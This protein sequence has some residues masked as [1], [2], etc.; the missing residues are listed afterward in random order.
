MEDMNQDSDI[1][2]GYLVKQ[3]QGV[4]GRRV[5]ELINHTISQSSE[6]KAILNSRKAKPHPFTIYAFHI[7]KFLAEYVLPIV[8]A[9][10]ISYTYYTASETKEP[11]PKT[12]KYRPTTPLNSAM[13][14]GG[15]LGEFAHGLLSVPVGIILGFMDKGLRLSEIGD[16]MVKSRNAIVYTPAAGFVGNEQFTYTISD[17]KGGTATAT[18]VV[19]VT[20]KEPGSS[21]KQ[22]F[23]PTVKR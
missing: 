4:Y 17:S 13:E 5:K 10:L 22:L 19:T 12:F 6:V 23:L 7:C 20:A 18:V 14:T 21:K 16:Y 1:H 9:A 15:F 3:P 11:L 8:I 2:T